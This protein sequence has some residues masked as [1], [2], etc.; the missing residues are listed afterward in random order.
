MKKK[1]K[2]KRQRRTRN[3]VNNIINCFCF[4]FFI[5]LFSIILR[6][7]YRRET[8]IYVFP[9]FPARRAFTPNSCLIIIFIVHAPVSFPAVTSKLPKEYSKRGVYSLFRPSPIGKGIKCIAY[10]NRA[11]KSRVPAFA[12]KRTHLS[13]IPSSA[14]PRERS[15][16][17]H[18]LSLSLTEDRDRGNRYSARFLAADYHDSKRAVEKQNPPSCIS[19]LRL[20]SSFNS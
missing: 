18:A 4:C 16:P 3:P 5:L 19:F 8:R 6:T 11:V 15:Y 20:K 10:G 14:V 13:S 9:L 12:P 1:K 7:G 2:R 17:S